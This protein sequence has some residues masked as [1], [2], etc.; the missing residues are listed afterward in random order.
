MESEI[1]TFPQPSLLS[2]MVLGTTTSLPL[3]AMPLRNR[4]LSNYYSYNKNTESSFD[5]VNPL[6]V[7]IE[8][9]DLKPP[10]VI[11]ILFTK[12]F[13]ATI[14]YTETLESCPSTASNRGCEH[15]KYA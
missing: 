3:V 4:Y 13:W 9:M 7:G 12:T 14:S 8:W 10:T 5:D 15:C 2:G 1:A 6:Q 11:L